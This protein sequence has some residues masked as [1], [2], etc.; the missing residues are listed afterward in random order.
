[1][2]SMLEIL[3]PKFGGL[4]TA[5]IPR[6]DLSVLEIP[7]TE[8]QMLNYRKNAPCEP[9]LATIQR[10]AYRAGSYQQKPTSTTHNTLYLS[11]D[12]FCNDFF[13]SWRQNNN[14]QVGYGEAG[15]LCMLGNRE[16]LHKVQNLSLSMAMLQDQ[17][18]FR[19]GKISH[20]LMVFGNVK[21]LFLATS[22]ECFE[23]DGPPTAVTPVPGREF[24]P[25]PCDPRGPVQRHELSWPPKFLEI[26]ES[27]QAEAI[28]DGYHWNI[29][30]TI[31]G[32]TMLIVVSQEQ[33]LRNL[34]A[35]HSCQ[36]VE[37]GSNNQRFAYRS[38]PIGLSL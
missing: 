31:Y 37:P 14:W 19:A 26:L 23:A 3:Q 33:H 36:P 9:I 7:P 10:I 28:A 35:T 2:S 38:W 8:I 34:H 32:E 16:E 11:E 12:S 30:N 18:R 15:L 27:L 20:I 6:A 22:I 17:E 21:R 29:P 25:P 13:T 24:V 1:M 5:E 4:T